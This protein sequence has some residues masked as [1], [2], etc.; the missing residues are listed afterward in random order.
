MSTIN[1]KPTKVITGKV[2]F[3]YVNIFFPRA[4]VSYQDPR[5]SLNI[6]IDREDKDTLNKVNSAIEAA[7]EAGKHLWG[8]TIP[9]NLISPLKDGNLHKNQQ[10]E[11]QNKFYINTSSKQKPGVV[12]KKLNPIVDSSEVYS[13]CYGRV[14][15]IFF[16]YD[17]EDK[18]GIGCGLLNV[19]MLEKGKS[20]GVHSRPEEDFEAFKEI[21]EDFLS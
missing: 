11:Y 14:S 9:Q 17:Q 16:P 6:I 10:E 5:F 21:E 2:R 15:V 7:K 1:N 18:K 4:A 20:L 8:G 13:G 12:D 19:Q 3:S